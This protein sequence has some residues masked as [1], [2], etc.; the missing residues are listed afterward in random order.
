M[1]EDQAVPSLT[2]S[3]SGFVNGDTA[4]ALDTPVQLTTTAASSSLA[5]TYPIIPSGARDANY[6]ITFVNGTLTINAAGPRLAT[7]AGDHGKPGSYFI[8]Q[9][10]GFQPHTTVR[11]AVD[12]RY[13]LTVQA[14]ANGVATF[15]LYFRP[16]SPIG[17]YT[18]TVTSIETA[19]QLAA[20]QVAQAQIILDPTASLLPKPSDPTLPLT[21]ALPTIYIPF[22]VQQ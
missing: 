19:I 13:V 7:T 11:I 12:G 17:S 1:E 3:Y 18:V 14:N 10:K 22:F 21:N 5:G 16:D 6:T 2:A 9:A 15:V 4:T 20:V 8:L